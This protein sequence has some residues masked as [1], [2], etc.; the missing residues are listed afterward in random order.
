MKREVWDTN[1]EKESLHRFFRSIFLKWYSRKS[2]SYWKFLSDVKFRFIPSKVIFCIRLFGGSR[3]WGGFVAGNRFRQLYTFA[4]A[5]SPPNL[6]S[7]HSQSFSGPV[8]FWFTTFSQPE[9]RRVLR[10]TFLF[11]RLNSCVTSGVDIASIYT[12]HKSTIFY[13]LYFNPHPPV[14]LGPRSTLSFSQQQNW[15]K[16]WTGCFT[17]LPFRNRCS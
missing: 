10:A 17:R 11:T 16:N 8:W 15:P 13:V 3:G 1:S 5:F 12:R 7:S 2:L 9:H 6:S 4:I 14:I